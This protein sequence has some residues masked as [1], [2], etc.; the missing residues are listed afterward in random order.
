MVLCYATFI[1]E[2]L[3]IQYS[4]HLRSE[5]QDCQT[6]EGSHLSVCAELGIFNHKQH[7]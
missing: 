4:E 2:R 7:I 1:S 3:K 5:T 6:D